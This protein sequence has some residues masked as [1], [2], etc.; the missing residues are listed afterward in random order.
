VEEDALLVAEFADGLD[1]LDHADFVVGVHDGDEDGLVG[2]FGDN[3]ALEVFDVDEAVGEDWQVGDAVAGLLETLAGVEGCLVLGDLGDD[4]VAALF[5]HL[6]S[7]LDGEVGGLGGAGG[8]DDFLGGRADEAG[9]LLARFLDTLLGFP[10]EGVIARRG[11][12]EDAG[13]VGH[14]GF[15]HAGIER[16]GRVVVHVDGKLDALGEGLVGLGDVDSEC[17]SHDVVAPKVS[18]RARCV[19]DVASVRCLRGRRPLLRGGGRRVR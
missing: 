19:N 9:D 1:G 11:V 13:E 14:H 12:A 15:E 4:V 17:F 16:R 8:E 7:A 6:G 3:G 10:A 2:A 5:V 18:R